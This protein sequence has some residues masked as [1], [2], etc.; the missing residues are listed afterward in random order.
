[1]VW[2]KHKERAEKGRGEVGWETDGTDEKNFLAHFALRDGVSI[3]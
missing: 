3:I 1:M 2:G